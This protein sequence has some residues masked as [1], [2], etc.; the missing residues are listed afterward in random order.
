MKS[1][2]ILTGIIALQGLL[3]FN[4]IFGR[5]T[6]I[7]NYNATYSEFFRIT[8]SWGVISLI[9]ILLPLILSQF[10]IRKRTT[11]KRIVLLF[12]SVLAVEIVFSITS[13]SFYEGAL[14]DFAFLDWIFTG[15]LVWLP[16]VVL[17]LLS[18]AL[19]SWKFHRR[20][21]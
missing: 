10:L 12:I 11:K 2:L 19:L 8:I 17:S 9:I 1:N 18:T 13:L 4:F 7:E 14:S 5:L 16:I 6:H 20:S 3:L 21:K 15:L